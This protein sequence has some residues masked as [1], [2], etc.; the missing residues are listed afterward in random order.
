M[1]EARILALC[2][3]P[4]VPKVDNNNEQINIK[5]LQMAALQ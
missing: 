5:H 4:P 2:V 3:H 1:E